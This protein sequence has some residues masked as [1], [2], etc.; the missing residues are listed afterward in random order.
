M[1]GPST[2]ATW[3]VALVVA[4][5]TREQFFSFFSHETPAQQRS[6]TE[7]RRQR[8]RSCERVGVAPPRSFGLDTGVAPHAAL[9]SA[10]ARRRSSPPPVTGLPLRAPASVAL[11][12]ASAA[13]HSPLAPR[14]VAGGPADCCPALAPH[15]AARSAARQPGAAARWTAKQ[16]Q[17]AGIQAN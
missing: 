3:A 1:G 17:G 9:R 15:S 2:R 16:E 14:Q 4:Q 6:S 12:S 8:Q 10:S 5:V 13:W 11:R 7:R